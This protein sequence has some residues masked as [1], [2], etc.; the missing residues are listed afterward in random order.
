MGKGVGGGLSTRNE[1]RGMQQNI[2]VFYWE[3]RETAMEGERE[4]EVEEIS[5]RN[6]LSNYTNQSVR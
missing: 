1:I 2:T 6:Q 4:R 3:E 5:D